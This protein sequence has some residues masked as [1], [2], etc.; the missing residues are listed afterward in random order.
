MTVLLP[1]DPSAPLPQRVLLVENSRA[2][3]QALA[4]AIGQQL[5]LP[6]EVA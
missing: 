2:Y 4:Q 6:V 5:E 1:I 3:V